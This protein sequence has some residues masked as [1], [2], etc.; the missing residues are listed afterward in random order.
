MKVLQ[1][2][3]LW[4]GAGERYNYIFCCDYEWKGKRINIIDTPDTLTSQLKWKEHF[5]FSMVQ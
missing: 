1:L 2:W 4:V 5:A 3:T